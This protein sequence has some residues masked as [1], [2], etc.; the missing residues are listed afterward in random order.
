MQTASPNVQGGPD[1]ADDMHRKGSMRMARLP[2]TTSW[3]PP[4]HGGA[5]FPRRSVASANRRMPA[6][7]GAITKHHRGFSR[8]KLA[9]SRQ[10]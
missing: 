1:L 2:L 4:I 10:L 3:S 8:L 5:V 6:P 9:G 7:N